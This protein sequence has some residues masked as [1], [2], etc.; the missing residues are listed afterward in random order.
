MSISVLAIIGDYYHPKEAILQSLEQS[1]FSNNINGEIQLD[2]CKPDQLLKKLSARPDA[3]V[4][5]TEDRVNPTDKKI[6]TWM[7]EEIANEIS[8][9]VKNGGSWLAWHSGLSSYSIDSNYTK[10]LRGYFEYHP[11]KHQ[12]VS[13]KSTSDNDILPE[14]VSFAVL[15]EHYFVHCDTENTT[16]FLLSESIDGQSIAGWHHSYGEGKVCCLTP[17]HNKEGLLDSTFEEVL[18]KCIMWLAK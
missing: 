12:V 15:D 16:V 2:L 5:F 1:L 4:L 18:K 14:D 8:Q 10:M 11:D 3:V 17:T 13:Y 9:Y 6:Y 7:T